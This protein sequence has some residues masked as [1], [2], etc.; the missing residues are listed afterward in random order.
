MNKVRVHNILTF[1]LPILIFG[2]LLYGFLNENS[3]MLI[4][5]VGYLVAYS[6]IRLEIHHYHHKWSAHGNT[7]FVKTLV[8]SDL[9]VVG[10]LLPTILAYSTMTDFSRNLMIFFIVGAFIYVTI[11]KIVDKISEHGLLVVS[12]VLSVLILITTKSIL[13]PTIFA[14]LSLWTYL[15][16]KH[17][18]VSYAK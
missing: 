13:E 18:L 17:D 14:L 8:I 4:Y 15:V 6:A 11:W 7:R 1:Y 2:S 12:L 16:L 10:F 9:V 5:A 3:Q